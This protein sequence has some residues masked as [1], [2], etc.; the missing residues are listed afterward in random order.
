MFHGAKMTFYAKI[1]DKCQNM[2]QYA[3]KPKNA[4][5]AG[6]WKKLDFLHNNAIAFF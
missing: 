5:Y 1:C 3:E 4:K 2:Q 6:N